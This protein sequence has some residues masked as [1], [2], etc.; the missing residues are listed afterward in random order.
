MGKRDDVVAGS[1][2]IEHLLSESFALRSCPV[3]VRAQN[4]AGYNDA[5]ESELLWRFTLQFFK[6][7]MTKEPSAETMG[8]D[9]WV[10]GESPETCFIAERGELGTELILSCRR[11]PGR[12]TPA[13]MMPYLYM[14]TGTDRPQVVL[15]RQLNTSCQE[16]AVFMP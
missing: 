6:K 4:T 11:R 13:V 2:V 5:A 7:D 10:T 12:M 1:I 3:E 15:N 16:P 14:A 9:V 8:D